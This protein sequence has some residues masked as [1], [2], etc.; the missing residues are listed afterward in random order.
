MDRNEFTRHL[1][2]TVTS[3][4]LFETLQYCEAY[5][6]PIR[7]IMGNWVKSLNEYCA[8]LKKSTISPSEWQSKVEELYA[9]IDLDEVIDNIEFN[10]LYRAFSYPDLGVGTK[11]VKFPSFTGIP[12]KTVFIKKIFGMKKDRAIIPHGHSNMASA[13]LIIK[14]KFYMRHYDKIHQEDKH[15]I[16]Q[17][18]V[19]K[20]VK[21]GDYSTISDDHDNIHW[22]IATSD[23]AFTF[24]V[25]MLD[26]NGQ[27]YDI[28]N[29]DIY[30]QESLHNGTIRV[31]EIDVEAGLKKYGKISHH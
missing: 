1:L 31:P 14:G 5:S 11:P 13:H 12:D 25:I 24:D 7:P 15:L 2:A 16:I 22:F 8:D 10:K 17:P 27:P 19:D 3:F 4:S 23:T 26:L 18:T 20:Q 9:T 28:H 21:K 6:S 30:K 29:I